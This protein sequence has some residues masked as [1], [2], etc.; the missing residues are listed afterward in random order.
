ML[1]NGSI[2]TFTAPVKRSATAPTS[3]IATAARNATR[4][5]ADPS[6]HRMTR[7][8]ARASRP[9]GA[10]SGWAEG[11]SRTGSGPVALRVRWVEP[12]RVG[13]GEVRLSPEDPDRGPRAH[14]ERDHEREHHGD[15]RAHGDRAHV[16]PHEPAHQRHRQDGGDDRDGREDGRVPDLVDRV[17]DDLREAPPRTRQVQVAVDVLDHHDGVVDQ[18]ADREDRARRA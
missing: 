12:A 7:R 11:S 9:S 13:L 16:R 14:D 8:S 18:D 6:S 10:V 4:T 3:S 5:F 1:S 17:E 15:A 2:L